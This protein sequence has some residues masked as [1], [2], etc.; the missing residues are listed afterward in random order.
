MAEPFPGNF[1]PLIICIAAVILTGSFLSFLGNALSCCSRARLRFLAQGNDDKYSRA[2]ELLEKPEY[3]I[4]S[5]RGGIIFLEILSGCLGGIIIAAILQLENLPEPFAGITAF[6]IFFFIIGM[7]FYLLAETLAK[8]I[9]GIAPEKITAFFSRFIIFFPVLNSPLLLLEKIISSLFNRIPGHSGMTEDE[10]HIAL[11]E[12]EKSGIVESRERTMVEGVFYLGDRPVGTFMTHRSELKWLDIDADYETIRNIARET[13]QQYIPV[14][15]SDLDRVS[16][17]VSVQ[18]ILLA[19]LEGPWPGL[20]SLMHK[21][22]FIPETMPALKAFETF[23]KAET[24]CL[25]VM[26]EYGGFAG[27]LTVRNLIEEITGQLSGRTGGADEVIRRDDGTWIMDGGINIDEAASVL[28][29][30]SLADEAGRSD[31]HTLAG[32][33]LNLAG[34]I[35]RTGAFM[36]YCGFRFTVTEMEGNRIVKIMIAKNR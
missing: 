18:E 24:L 21:P 9:A 23:K 13:R 14:A 33:I 7:I 2:L 17:I 5:L 30:S 10:L 15:E 16:G 29:L 35:P 11:L 1:Y 32:F 31:Y 27:I 25:F 19:L 4:K 20:K 36:D 8:E 6:I 22:C 34:E 12:G 3:Y 26:D 28:S